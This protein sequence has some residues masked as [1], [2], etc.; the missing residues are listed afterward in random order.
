D[1]VS[2]ANDTY[3]Q[4]YISNGGRELLVFCSTADGRIN[5][6]TSATVRVRGTFKEFQG[7]PEIYTR[8]GAIERMGK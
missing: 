7:T 2:D 6:S 3:Q 8:C 1:Y 5:V 4:F